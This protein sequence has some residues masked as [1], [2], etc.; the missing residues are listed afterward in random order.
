[1]NEALKLKEEVSKNTQN[2]RKAIDFV[3]ES[4]RDLQAK[5]KEQIKEMSFEVGMKIT[6]LDSRFTAEIENV[7]DHGASMQSVL[8]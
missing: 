5:I 8:D 7:R 6:G 3:K 2:V 4:Q 1:M